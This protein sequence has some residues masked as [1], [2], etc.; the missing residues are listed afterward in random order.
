MKVEYGIM[1]NKWSVNTEY[2]DGVRIKADTWYELK[3]GY[4]VEAEI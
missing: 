3:N 1:S 2:V 4:F